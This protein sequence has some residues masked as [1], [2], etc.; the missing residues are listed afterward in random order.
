MKLLN[1]MFNTSILLKIVINIFIVTGIVGVYAIGLYLLLI[2]T[3]SG[4]LAF[5]QIISF[6]S[7]ML[8]LW[9]GMIIFLPFLLFL[10]FTYES[11]YYLRPLAK[12]YG[13]KL[14]P[15]RNKEKDKDK[16]RFYI[17]AGILFAFI[18][19]ILFIKKNPYFLLIGLFPLYILIYKN[20]INGLYF[21]LGEAFKESYE[22]EK[23]PYIIRAFFFILLMHIPIVWFFQ[24][25]ML[26]SLADVFFQKI[27][28]EC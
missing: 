11:E 1:A 20:W 17:F 7:I 9:Y 26:Q 28:K 22:K 15:L 18:I 24:P 27:E 10:K 25:W 5:F 16:I 19:G 14:S 4:N 8:Y 3:F 6:L 2:M 13:R 21:S 12:T 23:Y